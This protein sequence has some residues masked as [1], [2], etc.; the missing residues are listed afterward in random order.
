M[1]RE[2]RSRRRR[3][4]VEKE[5]EKE[6][7]KGHSNERSVE[8]RSHASPEESSVFLLTWSRW[9]PSATS[10]VTSVSHDRAVF[11]S[12]YGSL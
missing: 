11:C 4:E 5:E 9:S 12:A 7:E 6:E 10:S 3:E 2:E 1:I 8:K